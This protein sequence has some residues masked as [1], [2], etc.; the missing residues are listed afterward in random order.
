MLYRTLAGRLLD[1]DRDLGE[2]ERHVLQKLVAWERLGLAP[3]EFA[4]R[5]AKALAQGWDRRGP[6]MPG[7]AFQA[8]ADDLAKRLALAGG[9]GPG[10]FLAQAWPGRYAGG[11]LEA[12]ATARGELELIIH[13]A[14]DLPHGPLAW[15]ALP[16]EDLAQAQERA[17]AE[18]APGGRLAGEIRRLG[19]TARVPG[20]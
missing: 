19:L 16:G 10:W 8:L 20:R 6:L 5:R 7:A 11:G 1:T 18:T 17:L 2:A 13:D 3:A 12:R 15:P 9:P 14:A 4:L